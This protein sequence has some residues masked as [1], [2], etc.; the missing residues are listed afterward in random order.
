MCHGARFIRAPGAYAAVGPD[1][2]IWS[3]HILSYCM[4]PGCKMESAYSFI[5][6]RD[7][8]RL[9]WGSPEERRALLQVAGLNHFLFSRELDIHDPL[10][11]SPLFSP[12]NIGRH[13]GVR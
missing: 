9:M 7:W 8:D 11:R 12:E 6:T 1:V 10:P 5:M 13:F 2:P 4:L 3:L